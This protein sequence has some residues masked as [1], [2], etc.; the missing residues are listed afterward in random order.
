MKNIDTGKLRNL[1]SMPG[2]ESDIKV[3]VQIT[4]EYG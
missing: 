2:S 1:I 4:I 3:I